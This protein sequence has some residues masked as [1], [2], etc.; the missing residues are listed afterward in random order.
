[1]LSIA[2]IKSVALEILLIWAHLFRQVS[3]LRV[4]KNIEDFD[5]FQ[6]GRHSKN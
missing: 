5:H 6:G 2:Q 1:M 4:G 3:N